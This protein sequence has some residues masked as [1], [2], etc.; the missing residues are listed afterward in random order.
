MLKKGQKVRI[1]YDEDKPFS[2]TFLS[3]LESDL[4]ADVSERKLEEIMTAIE[5]GEVFTVGNPEKSMDE[6]M[7]NIRLKRY[8]LPYL[9]HEENLE[10]IK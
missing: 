2:D 6:T 9:F 7:Y 1:T 5:Q 3:D 4:M 8:T 10:V